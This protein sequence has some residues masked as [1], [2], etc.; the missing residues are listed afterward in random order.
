MID[1]FLVAFVSNLSASSFPE[2]Y[3]WAM[4]FQIVIL[5]EE[6]FFTIVIMGAKRSLSRWFNWDEGVLMWLHSRYI[7]LRLYV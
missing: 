1:V 3:V 2:I 6:F 5:C 7:W 4:T